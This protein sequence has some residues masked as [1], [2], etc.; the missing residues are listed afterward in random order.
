MIDMYDFF[1]L[2]GDMRQAYLADILREQGYCVLDYLLPEKD[3]KTLPEEE[4]SRTNAGSAGSLL[5]EL[6]KEEKEP[7]FRRQEWLLEHLSKSGTVLAPIPLSK[8]GKNLNCMKKEIQLPLEQMLG[9]LIKGQY[10]FAG[11]IPKWFAAKCEQKGICCYDYMED[12]PLAVRNAVATAEG[13]LAEAILKYPGNLHDT[14]CLV[15][16][17][18]KCGRVLAE[19]L[20]GLSAKVTVC[21]RKDSDYAWAKACGYEAVY[22]DETPRGTHRKNCPETA[23]LCCQS[24]IPE[25]RTA[26][27][28]KCLLSGWIAAYPL[29]FNT[30]PSLVLDR[31]LLSRIRK[32]AMIFDLASAPG[33]VDYEAARRLKIEAGLYQSLPGKYAPKASAEVMAELIKRVIRKE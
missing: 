10:F 29:I 20:K 6:L 9:G 7:E 30:V 32:D 33:G 16:G 1:V 22:F 31:G 5:F 14:K 15:L 4:E 13:V 21:I 28:E 11:C 26:E 2:G 19:K 18:G 17:F 3:G 25:D 8:D 23:E 12:E 24:L 27:E